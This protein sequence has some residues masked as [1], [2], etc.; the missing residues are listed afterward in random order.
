MYGPSG[1]KTY[2]ASVLSILSSAQLVEQSPPKFLDD[3]NNCRQARYQDRQTKKG[4]NIGTQ[5][6]PPQTQRDIYQNSS[7]EYQYSVPTYS[8]FSKLADFIPGN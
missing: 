5:R 6:G 4:R 8:R 2:T 1:P 3:H 7:T